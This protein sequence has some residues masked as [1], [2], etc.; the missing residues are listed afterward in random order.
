MGSIKRTAADPHRVIRNVKKIVI[1]DSYER[2][3]YFWGSDIAILAMTEP[4]EFNDYIR[5]VCLPMRNEVFP[6]SSLCY[7]SGWGYTDFYSEYWEKSF[8]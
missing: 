2:A 5:P 4:I 6:V 8:C 7:V 3:F 1:P